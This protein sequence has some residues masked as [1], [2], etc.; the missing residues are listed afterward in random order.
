METMWLSYSKQEFCALADH[1]YRIFAQAVEERTEYPIA[2]PV[3]LI[4][5]EKDMA[6][7][8]KSYNRRWTKI[9]DHRLEWIRGAGHNSNTDA[10]EKVNALIEEFVR[11]ME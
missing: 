5:G 6:G 3:L 10:P 9:D 4:C 11:K 7:S 8:A 1:G 2:C